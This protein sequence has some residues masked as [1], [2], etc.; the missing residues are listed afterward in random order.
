[1]N[2]EYFDLF[3]QKAF[4]KGYYRMNNF[5]NKY[6]RDHEVYSL[7]DN[8]SEIDPYRSMEYFIMSKQHNLFK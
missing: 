5:I 8:F 7:K 1:M 2:Y 4:N 3:N 6:F